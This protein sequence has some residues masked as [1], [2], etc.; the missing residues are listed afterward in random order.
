MIGQ[1]D[2]STLRVN[3]SG[4]DKDGLGLA[5]GFQ[6]RVGLAITG[7]TSQ[8]FKPSQYL[9]KAVEGQGTCQDVQ[10]PEPA[11]ERFALQ[12]PLELSERASRS[13]ES[14]VETTLVGAV[15][16]A[17]EVLVY[18]LVHLENVV[19]VSAL[20]IRPLNFGGMGHGYRNR[21]KRVIQGR[22]RS[23][24]RKLLHDSLVHHDVAQ[25]KRLIALYVI[26]ESANRVVQ[27]DQLFH[28]RPDRLCVRRVRGI[29]Q[30]WRTEGEYHTA[31]VKP[32]GVLFHEITPSLHQITS[33]AILA[34][35]PLANQVE[36]GLETFNQ[37][38]HPIV[39]LLS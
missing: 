6:N 21:R 30:D 4:G 36:F 3:Y 31:G 13:P 8:Y 9:P 20:F 32:V 34:R 22:G 29:I 5:G 25:H 10:D 15:G 39:I 26:K 7:S 33:G 35:C 28:D 38:Q 12:L 17:Y 16:S 23:L 24:G 37:A 19:D 14:L 1:P 11:R 27:Y 2:D 18:R